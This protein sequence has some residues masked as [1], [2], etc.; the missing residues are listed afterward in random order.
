VRTF[1][2]K[3]HV[4]PSP[5]LTTFFPR[6]WPGRITLRISG[7]RFEHEVL[8]P[9]GDTDDPMTWEEVERKWKRALRRPGGAD[10]IEGLKKAVMSLKGA[11]KVDDLLR[12]L[13]PSKE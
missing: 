13:S 5:D 1:M 9:K 10:Q 2:K 12:A 3:V 7:E 8:A 11:A 6:K 4:A